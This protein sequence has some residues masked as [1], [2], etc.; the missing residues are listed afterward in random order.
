MDDNTL[1]T[2]LAE[3]VE[4]LHQAPDPLQT[5]EQVVTYA[6]EQLNADYAGISL[7]K[8]A[9]R[10]QT[11]AP[12][13][14]VVEAADQLQYELREGPCHDSAWQGQTMVSQDLAVE[15]RW[16]LWAPKAVALGLG[17]ALGAELVNKAGDRRLGSVNLYWTAPRVFTS[18]EVS[19]AHLITRHA[20]LALGA[21]LTVEGL[22]IALDGRKRIGQAQGILMERHGL[23][24]DQAFAVL[25]R[26]SQDNNTKLRDL[27]EQLVTTRQLPGGGR[28]ER[29]DV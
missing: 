26:Y 17:S 20:A 23:S 13:H 28:T 7:I 8:S 18:D 27:A 11:V 25:K 2:E 24:E 9:G 5:A 1:A 19:F 4:R 6:R 16:P 22:N 14:P 12:T 10:L 21:S 3:L 29:A 15:R